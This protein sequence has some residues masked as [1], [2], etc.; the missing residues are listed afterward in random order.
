MKLYHGTQIR[1]IKQLEPFATRG[2][3]ISKPVIYAL[4]PILVLLC[5]TYGIVLTNGSL[6]VKMKTAKWFLQST[7]KI[8][9]MIFISK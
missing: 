4:H 5:Y 2:N 1:S 3:A 8:C 6:L 9:F 7:M